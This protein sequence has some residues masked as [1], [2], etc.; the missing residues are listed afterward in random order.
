MKNN[1]AINSDDIIKRLLNYIIIG[2]NKRKS[3]VLVLLSFQKT[4]D[5][6][7]ST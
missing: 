1:S 2:R 6:P 4:L 5:A 7:T 3:D